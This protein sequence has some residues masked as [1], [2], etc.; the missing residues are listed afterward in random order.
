MVLI[1]G[2]QTF[3]LWV[4]CLLGV[5]ILTC[6]HIPTLFPLPAI[7]GSFFQQL[8]WQVK[9]TLLYKSTLAVRRLTQAHALDKLH[10]TKWD[11]MW[12]RD[13]LQEFWVSMYHAWFFPI[14]DGSFKCYILLRRNSSNNFA[15]F[16]KDISQNKWPP[17]LLI[18]QSLILMQF[19]NSFR[20]FIQPYFFF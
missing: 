16:Y 11:L 18:S 20:L 15:L 14:D 4:Q 17:D 5:P 10:W 9:K 1:T 19:R 7:T 2:P 3:S 13:I 12:G 6:N 8:S